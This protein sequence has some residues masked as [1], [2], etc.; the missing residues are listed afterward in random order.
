[1]TKASISTKQTVLT[2]R[3]ALVSPRSMPPYPAQSD[4]CV[5]FLVVS[6]FF[7]LVIISVGICIVSELC[8]ELSLVSQT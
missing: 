4:I 8:V 7:V 1:M 2:D 3:R 5:S 6:T